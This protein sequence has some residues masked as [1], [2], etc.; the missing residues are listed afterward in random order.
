[1][2]DGTL[3]GCQN[4]I[5]DTNINFINTNDKFLYSIKKDQVIHNRILNPINASEEDLQLLFYTHDILRKYNFK[6]L[7]NNILNLM[8]ILAKCN[9]IDNNYLYNENE[10]L[11]FAF[12]IAKYNNCF[13]NALIKTGNSFFKNCGIIRFLCNGALQE[14]ILGD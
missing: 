10:L 9:Q 4:Q 1:M 5:F 11:I 3:L 2:Y 13:Y 7:Y 12:Y 8:Y 14:I 6:I